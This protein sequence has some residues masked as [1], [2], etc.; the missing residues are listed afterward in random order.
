M[1]V[2]LPGIAGQIPHYDEMGSE[3]NRL[4]DRG[5]CRWVGVDGSFCLAGWLRGMRV[6]TPANW[7]F[8]ELGFHARR[9]VS[10]DLY[11]LKH[12]AVVWTTGQDNALSEPLIRAIAQ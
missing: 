10:R 7:S 9:L 3:L 12:R 5:I 6:V 11:L 1:P 2:G 8:F 4:G